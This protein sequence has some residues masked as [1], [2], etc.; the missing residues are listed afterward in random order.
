M[1]DSSAGDFPAATAAETASAEAASA[2][3]GFF[4]AVAS[5][6]SAAASSG[7]AAASAAGT[8]E[9]E[10]VFSASSGSAAEISDRESAGSIPSGSESGSL[11]ASADAG[12]EISGGGADLCARSAQRT[13]AAASFSVAE[14]SAQPAF[15]RPA[16]RR[17]P[18]LIPSSS[19]VSFRM[20]LQGMC[21]GIPF[22]A[23]IPPFGMI[24][25]RRAGERTGKA[26]RT[27][28]PNTSQLTER[29][30]FYDRR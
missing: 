8:A 19:P 11:S 9:T 5:A 12:T 7:S 6:G 22:G 20:S 10:T 13:V 21:R 25:Y 28:P 23:C 27:L 29:G 1:P 24:H 26:R 14:L 2:Q 3:T 30:G 4:T 17:E 16:G 18:P 15:G